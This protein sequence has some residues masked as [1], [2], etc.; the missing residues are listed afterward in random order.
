[1]IIFHARIIE[2]GAV[3]PCVRLSGIKYQL[4][5]V[6]LLCKAEYNK[7]E[8]A[9]LLSVVHRLFAREL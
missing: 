8:C 7:T 1:M 9:V 6:F 3:D 4:H 2:Y 5:L